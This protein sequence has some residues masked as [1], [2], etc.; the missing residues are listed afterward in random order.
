MLKHLVDK[1]EGEDLG[2]KR[3][4]LKVLR[5]TRTSFE[6]QILESVQLQANRERHLLNSKSEYNRCA[7]PR[8]SSKIGEKEYRKW[9]A[10]EKEEREKDLQIEMK[11]RK[12]RKLRNK[13]RIYKEMREEDEEINRNSK[14]RRRNLELVQNCVGEVVCLASTCGGEVVW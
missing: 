7:I 3:F 13:N 4:A 9:S 12:L 14:R 5:F 8:L 11:V 10:D 6:R 2:K 1:H